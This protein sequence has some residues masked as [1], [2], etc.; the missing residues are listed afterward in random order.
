MQPDN[1][2]YLRL[3][4]VGSSPDSGLI[5]S[6]RYEIGLGLARTSGKPAQP[7]PGSIFFFIGLIASHHAYSD[8]AQAYDERTRS[9]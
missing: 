2:L 3:L 9:V 7:E 5:S 4:K 6:T 1:G 8:R